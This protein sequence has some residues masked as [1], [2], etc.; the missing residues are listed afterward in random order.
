MI[1]D[2]TSWTGFINNQ[3]ITYKHESEMYFQ[4]KCLNKLYQ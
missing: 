3:M 2:L 4:S 1:Y